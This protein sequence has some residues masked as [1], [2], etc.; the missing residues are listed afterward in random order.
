MGA[1]GYKPFDND[2]AGEWAASVA[3]VLAKKIEAALSRNPRRWGLRTRG[4]YDEIRAAADM[5]VS[6]ASDKVAI[7]IAHA[8]VERIKPKAVRALSL[9]LEDDEYLD[10][11]QDPKKIRKSISAQIKQLE[12]LQP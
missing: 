3:S 1:W 7:H 6:L 10:E 12:K 4:N 9:I 8:D 2:E 5:F 11:W